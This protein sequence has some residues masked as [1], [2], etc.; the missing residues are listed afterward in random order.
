MLRPQGR[1]IEERWNKGKYGLEYL[2]CEDLVKK[3]AWDLDV[4]KGREKLFEVRK[5]HNDITFLDTFLDEEFC[6]KY[7]L[8]IYNF[9]HRSSKNK[10]S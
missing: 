6:R 3:E 4:M 1:H 10:V 9:D 2:N 8:F 7:K 5:I